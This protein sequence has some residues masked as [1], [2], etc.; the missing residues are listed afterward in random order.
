MIF[1]YGGLR[2]RLKKIA[3]GIITE[4]AYEK[5]AKSERKPKEKPLKKTEVKPKIK[6]KSSAPAPKPAEPIEL[7]EEEL[8]VPV[9]T[10]EPTPTIEEELGPAQEPEVEPVISTEALDKELNDDEE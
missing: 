3:K 6:Q 2:R 8:F 5:P 7:K 10:D 1:Y 9:H 4:D